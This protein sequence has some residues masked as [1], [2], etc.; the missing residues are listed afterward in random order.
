MHPV[1]TFLLAVLILFQPL[2]ALAQ[3]EGMSQYRTAPFGEFD[4]TAIGIALVIVMVI[5]GF[6]ALTR[7]RR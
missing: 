3:G 7:R 2:A 4:L 5:L 6:R 1:R